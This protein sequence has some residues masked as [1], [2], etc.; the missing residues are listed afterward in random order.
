MNLVFC[1]SLVTLAGTNIWR[2]VA[3]LCLTVAVPAS[4]QSANTARN[5]YV[6]RVVTVQRDD[7]SVSG[8]V[9]HR[10]GV[11]KFRYAIA[12]FPGYPGIV[13]LR[14]EQGEPRFELRGNFLVR[15]R[16]HWL[17][18]D[19]LTVVIDAPSD[20][21]GTFPQTFRES[22]RY[23]ADVD[24]LLGEIARLFNVQDWTYVGTSEGS[25]SAYHA[26]GMS[27]GRANR[28]ILTSTLFHPTR[29]GPGLS[30]VKWTDLN[31]PLLWVHH[32]SDPCDHTPYRDAQAF[33]IKSRAPLVTVRGG[34]PERG[35]L[36][37]AFTSHG[38]VGVEAETVAAMSSWVKTSIV[39]AD[40]N[41]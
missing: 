32:E 12:L 15:S 35:G 16:E 19:T 36:C 30:R 14:V 17:D 22:A 41:P 6:D 24:A 13:K 34:G 37:N 31:T 33:A 25:V 21:W 2:L 18:D 9:T 4:A 38:F 10:H 23:G 11:S 40:V 20:Q 3:A 1:E 39:P 7:Y 8:L 28:L 5:T 29:N 26:A 27:T